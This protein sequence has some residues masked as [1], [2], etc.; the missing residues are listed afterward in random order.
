MGSGA[1]KVQKLTHPSGFRL[2]HEFDPSTPAVAYHLWVGVGSAHE[3]VSERGASHFLE[4]ML[5]K[6]TETLDSVALN[7]AIEN[8]GG[9][10]NAYT[11]YEETA[12]H[13]AL[14]SRS[15]NEGLQILLDMVF[16]SQLD[17]EEMEIERKVILEELK[18]GEDALDS[19]L[20]DRFFES[21]YPDHGYGRP[22]IGKQAEVRGLGH[23]ELLGFYRR[24]YRPADMVLAVVGNMEWVRLSEFVR[25]Y[26]NEL[27]LDGEK[28]PTVPEVQALRSPAFLRI[29]K[30]SEERIMDIAF[31]IPGIR[32]PDLPVI[33]LLSIVLGEGDLSRLHVLL[34]LEKKVVR[35]VA[36]SLYS[37]E[38]TG[39]FLIRAFLYKDNEQE[40]LRHVA[41]EISRVRREGISRA[42]LTRAKA[43][44]EKELLFADETAEGRAR[45]LAHYEWIYGDFEEEQRYRARI[46]TVTEEEVTQA[47]RSYLDLGKT[48]IGLLLPASD[49]VQPEDAI[50]SCV[51]TGEE[52]RPPVA[53]RSGRKESVERFTLSNGVRVV[54]RPVPASRISGLFGTALGGLWAE[55]PG[56]S[57]ISNLIGATLDHG[58]CT[59]TYEQ[60]AE[61]ASSLQGELAS[62]VGR[63]TLG[64]RMDV[65][66]ANLAPA[67]DL[68]SDILLHPLFQEPDVDL[69]RRVALRELEA[70]RDYFEA[71]AANVFSE[72]LFKGHPYGMNLLGTPE[73][74]RRL[75]SKNL[76]EHYRMTLAPERMVLGVVGPLDPSFLK[77]KLEELTAKLPRRSR[78]LSGGGELRPLSEASEVRRPIQGEKAYALYGFL[79]P[80]IHSEERYALDVL[81]A[82]L[83]SSG[84][85]RLYVRL[86]EELGLLY[87]VEVSVFLGLDC[88]AIA[89]AFNTA[90][91]RVD[92]ALEEIRREIV[93]LQKNG[94]EPE[95]LNRVKNFIAGNHEIELQRSGS[96]AV[97]L[98]LGELYG[99]ERTLEDYTLGVLKVSAQDVQSVA[100][101]YL[102]PEKSVL[103]LLSPGV[104]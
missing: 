61:E 90:T 20:S 103:A 78:K 11:S 46:R 100:E 86:R 36:T 98:A 84:G 65:A 63:N 1:T 17:E 77:E 55:D 73:S 74:L 96:Q 25:G 47:A 13:M 35:S 48:G 6:G 69:E 94:V 102:T 39:Q 62:V 68:F 83:A 33:D 81:S 92:R 28:A 99:T 76:R 31:P 71:A 38:R 40:V 88:G 91:D 12:Y 18:E 14:S 43:Q 87:T 54:F 82:V 21:L 9:N 8:L 89:V 42:E 58:T 57:G 3:G 51:E 29:Q 80:S 19:L 66:S 93:E 15:W 7:D 4:H 75:R 22:I 70:Q 23:R 53:K 24:W 104:H 60:V 50:R 67:L 26:L 32:H 101:K 2:V 79:G 41:R 52:A 64:L 85:G 49:P 72:T 44:L 56:K 27:A 37:P 97:A 59:R 30:G 16:K 5:F 34:K 10:V 45:T 95:E